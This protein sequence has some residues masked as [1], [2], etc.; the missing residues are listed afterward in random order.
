MAKL[1]RSDREHRHQGPLSEEE[2]Q[3]LSGRGLHVTLWRHLATQWGQE[4]DVEADEF[5][6][7]LAEPARATQKLETIDPSL[8]GILA[9]V[10]HEGGRLRGELLRKAY[11]LRTLD[12]HHAAH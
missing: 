10:A 4:S 8:R 12:R 9:F 5:A 3:W 6:I 11:L 1:T 7:A 2:L